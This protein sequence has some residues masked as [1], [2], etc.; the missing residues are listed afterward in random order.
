VFYIHWE[1]AVFE[2]CQCFQYH[3][4]MHENQIQVMS[5]AAKPRLIFQCIFHIWLTVSHVHVGCPLCSELILNLSVSNTHIRLLRAPLWP[6]VLHTTA[7]LH[8]C[9]V[10]S[11]SYIG[12]WCFFLCPK[13]RCHS[14][15]VSHCKSSLLNVFTVQLCASTVY[16]VALCM[17][18]CL[19]VTGQCSTKSAKC[20]GNNANDSL[21]ILVVWCQR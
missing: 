15:L 14:K 16:A 18:I 2:P 3:H 11:H 12:C 7:S 19:S 5:T 9:R 8:W 10:A 6:T 21:G 20:Y 4:Q 1:A 13:V 17:T